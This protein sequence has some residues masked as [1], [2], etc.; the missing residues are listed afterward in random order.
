MSNRPGLGALAIQKLAS[1]ITA[2]GLGMVQ[3]P[4]GLVDVPSILTIGKE[5]LHLG[6]YLTNHLRKQVGMTDEEISAVKQEF[7]YDRQIEML[8]LLNDKISLE[9]LSPWSAKKIY[10]EVNAQKVREIHSR[11]KIWQQKK[12]SL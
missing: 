3:L 8:A 2:S 7:T 1:T 6:R 12:G 9:P 10:Q 5:K 11:Y 4:S